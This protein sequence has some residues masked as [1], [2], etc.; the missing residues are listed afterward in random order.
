MTKD[1]SIPI[2]HYPPRIKGKIKYKF[3]IIKYR[4]E[5]KVNSYF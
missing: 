1:I 3:N 5:I 2:I 4:N